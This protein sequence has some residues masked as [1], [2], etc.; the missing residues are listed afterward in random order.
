MNRLMKR[1]ALYLIALVAGITA[2]SCVR[3]ERAVYNESEA[4]APIINSFFVNEDGDV[5][6]NF[7]PGS[8]GQSFN[9]KMPVNHSLVL[10]KADDKTAS[11][12]LTSSVDGDVIT[13]T[14]R[15]LSRGLAAM[16]Y[17][18]G[19]VVGAVELSL[20]ASLQEQAR[21]N[22]RNGY[23]ESE[24]RVNLEDVL[25][26]LPQESPYKEYTKLSNWTV[27]GSIAAYEMDWNKDLV[28]WTDGNHNF[29]APH[30]TLGKNDEFKFR[31]DM[32]WDVNLGGEFGGLDSEFAI[33]EGGANIKVGEDGI[34]D[35]FF[36]EETKKAWVLD[37]FDPYPAFTE[38]SD[39]SVIGKLKN[40]N[41]DWNDDI[42]MISDGTSHLALGVSLDKADEFKFRKDKD[43]TVNL[44]GEFGGLGNEFPVTQ[45][46]SNIK[47]GEE[48]EFDL[49]I[50]PEAGTAMVSEA[51]GA[52]VSYLAPVPAEPVEEVVWGIIGLN[53]DWDHDI[54]ATEQDGV[55]SV[56]VTAES[57]CDFK[58]RKNGSWDENYGGVMK[59]LGEPFAAVAGG[60]NIKIA[61][62]GFYQIVL[63]LSDAENPTITI[64]E[65]SDVYSL[66]GKING[67]N[68]D[69]DFDLAEDAGVFTSEVVYI[70]GGF[71]IR[72]NYSWADAD[73]YGAEADGFTPEMGAAF[74]VVQPGKDITLPAGNY[75][76]QFTLETKQV[77]ITK[78]DYELP[79]IDLTQFTELPEMAGAD[80]WGIIG[81]AQTGGWNTDTDLQKIQDDP[82]VWAVMN[83]PLQADKFKFRGNDE[84]GAYDLG[85][86]TWAMNEPFVMTVKGGDMSVELG[87]Y[88]VY[89]YPTYGV[90][91]FTE[92]SGDVPPPP[93]KPTMWSLVGTIGGT[94]W[95]ADLDMTNTSGD[96]WE[97]KNVAITADD[98]FKIRADHDWNTCV[99]GPEGNA[100]STID[101]AD[102]YDVYAPTIGTAFAAG[103]KNIRIGVAGN[104]D[105]YF[106][107]DKNL[108]TILE[109]GSFPENSWGLVGT[110]NNWGDT[111][112][113]PLMEDGLFLAAKN[114]ALTAD[115]EIKIRFNQNW[116]NNRGGMS[117]V[118]VPVKAV[119]SG[120]NIKPGVA[121][122]Y[123]VYY[124]PDCEVIIVT[125][126]GA[127]LNYWGVVGTIN[128]WGAPDILMYQNADGLLESS[129]IELTA[130]DAF[131]IRMNE[132]WT[133]DR[134]GLFGELDQAF[135][136][137]QGGPNIAL[138]RDAKIQVLYNA[139]S[140]TITITGEYTGDVPAFPDDIYAVGGDTDWSA[141]YQLHGKNGQY[142]GFGY[143]SQEFKF[144]P[145]P[146]TWDGNWGAGT[147]SGTIALGGGNLA[148]PETAGYYMI[149]AD[150]G[151]M[152]YKLTLITTIGIIGP[153]QAGGWETDTDLT[154]NAETKAWEATGVVLKAG[155]MKFRAN[156]A[157]DIN[158][159]GALNELVQ[160]GDNIAVEAGTYDIALYAW[161]D[162]KAYATLTEASAPVATGITIDGDLSDWDGIT[163]F[164]SSANSR[165]REWKYSSDAEN[166]Y[167]YFAMRKNRVDSGRK[168]VIGFDIDETGSLTDN[169]NLKSAEA[170]AR[171]IIPFTNASGATELTVVKGTDAGSE[172]VSTSGEASTGVVNVYAVA[173]SED[174]STD[175][176]NAYV[177]LSIPKNKLGLPAAGTT[178]KIGASYDYY[179]AGWQEITL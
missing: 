54:N 148:A 132:T 60:D 31:Q 112:D 154:Y 32:A 145:N 111:P 9:N 119:P 65:V 155:D 125:E 2:V 165:I 7:T 98:E 93:A 100:K 71:K 147:D 114:V 91:Y 161:C 175:S 103:D 86:G 153:A 126:A 25:V 82:E 102:P 83:I 128:S 167:F 169:N 89:L 178:I 55:W 110:I 56:F 17:V 179:F 150:L 20:R 142:K 16:G 37:A 75:R 63:D 163:A 80:T 58:W 44:G 81:P 24:Q 159:G 47:V 3:E 53:G 1:I 143:L 123:D 19:D 87:V 133:V 36:N 121:G 76:V 28:M 117:V 115:D 152:T 177:E 96:K 105:V 51:S 39:W 18:D 69:T 61:A 95:D 129:E 109:A 78:V 120:D 135:D 130:T 170:I 139:A 46:G 124:R 97:V 34:F 166:V 52:K 138:G 15:N 57:S 156:D 90:A 4:I 62:A 101:P 41:I 27:I 174:I 173:G 59:A 176:S 162:G 48:G 21:D 68:W 146:D 26:S 79:E 151:E 64:S 45:D 42:A 50:N 88:T 67:T 66:I 144:R 38:S 23:I 104:Y 158:W 10:L 168:L 157:W 106:D 40:Y 113:T 160:G 127:E 5:I 72:H 171:N 134:G 35:I 30:V 8:M 172:V 94:S 49:L 12:V 77:V 116:D 29:V 22:G 43:W 122:N 118:G 70:D 6:V 164:S 108:I 149:E 92:G 140:E 13:V 84:W 107:A 99:G 73:T 137:T 14:S 131:K 85:G 136:V 141:N 74:T 11:R 33:T